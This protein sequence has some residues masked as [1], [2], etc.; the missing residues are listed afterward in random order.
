MVG[1]SVEAGVSSVSESND[2]VDTFFDAEDRDDD[3]LGF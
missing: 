1:E 3:G 2:V